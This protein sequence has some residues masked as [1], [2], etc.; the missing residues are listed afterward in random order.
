MAKKQIY[1]S[2]VHIVCSHIVFELAINTSSLYRSDGMAANLSFSCLFFNFPSASIHLSSAVM[3]LYFSA[4]KLSDLDFTWQR[5]NVRNLFMKPLKIARGLGMHSNLDFR[6]Q[7]YLTLVDA[8]CMQK[9]FFPQRKSITHSY[10]FFV[11]IH[12]LNYEN[13]KPIHTHTHTIIY[14]EIMFIALK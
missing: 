5:R 12:S 3:H 14:L 7:F 1:L 4:I 8:A 11:P 2:N 13:R 9:H 6:L 10:D